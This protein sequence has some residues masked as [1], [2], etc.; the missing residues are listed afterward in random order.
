MELNYGL[1]SGGA[2]FGMGWSL[3]RDGWIS[4]GDGY[5]FVRD[6]VKLD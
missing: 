1:E 3:I 5:S 6:G 4:I 2:Q